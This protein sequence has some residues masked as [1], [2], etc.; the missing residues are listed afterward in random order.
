ML[1]KNHKIGVLGKQEKSLFQEEWSG[2]GKIQIRQILKI[3]IGF[4]NVLTSGH[5]ESWYDGLMRREVLSQ[6]QISGP[7]LNYTI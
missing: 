6:Q 7:L 5:S 1:D 2:Y 4:G 3:S